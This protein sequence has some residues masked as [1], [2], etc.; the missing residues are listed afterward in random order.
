V[1][2]NNGSSQ[3]S[4]RVALL[5]REG[6]ARDKLRHTL[7]EIGADIVLETDPLTV[8]AA[9]LR[10]AAP[11][12]VLV[13]LEPAV[14]DAL[15]A[16][17]EVLRAADIAVIFDDAELA[18]Q[19]EGWDAQR[20]ARHLS[21]K[22]H[23]HDNVLPPGHEG[24]AGAP[25]VSFAGL[26]LEDIEPVAEAAPSAPAAY[27]FTDEPAAWT[28]PAQAPGELIDG[29]GAP[30]PD[31][32]PRAAI[33]EP[34]PEPPPLPPELP[35][36]EPAVARPDFSNLSL[37]IEDA[38]P[39]SAPAAG[40]GAPGALLMFAGIGGPDAVRRVLAE[41][42]QAF[43]QPVLLHLRLDGGR[44]DNLVRQLERISP[45]PVALAAAGQNADAGHVYVVPEDVA[46]VATASGVRFQPGQTDVPALLRG[47]P[48]RR[49]AALLLSGSDPA[50]VDAVLAMSALGGYVAGQ[51]P[52]GCYDPAAA[53]ALQLRGGAIGA[54]AELAAGVI[55]HSY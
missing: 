4:K 34:A 10:A 17:D 23:G 13:A 40:G 25:A 27:E 2:A 43:P 14:E 53:K 48:A 19:R 21:A 51:S 39:S 49:S 20:W 28:P 31:E 54:P 33:A 12:A 15:P 24:D 35:P 41:L 30:R 18:A 16:L 55:E 29:F 32:P 11:H 45:M 8:D 1:S 52:Q 50:H 44:Y 9:A 6:K 37:E 42:P 22:L 5:A 26:A 46:A 47:L 38:S 7:R 3:D 36:A